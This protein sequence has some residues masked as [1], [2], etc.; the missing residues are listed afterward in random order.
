MTYTNEIP[1]MT[2]A[3]IPNFDDLGRCIYKGWMLRRN[4]DL[5]VSI[6]RNAA[7]Y[8]T[9][10]SNFVEATDFVDTQA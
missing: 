8:E 3:A 6:F 2:N 7:N 1:T 10:L 4:D 9:T 5:S